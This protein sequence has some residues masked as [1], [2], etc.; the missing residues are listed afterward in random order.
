M[1]VSCLFF[2]PEALS[3]HSVSLWI[4]YSD[5]PDFENYLG[6][7]YP[8]EPEIKDTKE[9]IPSASYLDLLPSTVRDGKLHTSIYDKREDFNFQITNFSFLSSHIPSSPVNGVFISHLIRYARACSSYECF[10]PRAT[11]LCSKLL[12][13]KYLV[14]YLISS[15]RKSYGRY[16]D[17]IQ[18]FEVSLSRIFNDILTL[19]QFQ[20]LTNRSDFPTISWRWYRALSPPNYEW[21]SW[22]MCSGCGM[23]A[24][25][26]Y[27]SGHLVPSPFL[28]LAYAPIL[29]R[30]VFRNLPCLFTTIH[31]EYPS[32]LSWVFIAK[33]NSE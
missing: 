32:V 23:P 8:A 22:S 17:L 20:W 33:K 25:N 6:Q 11:R 15:F 12:K 30:P 26:A 14:E 2:K 19:D 21:S 1:H 7:V 5:N 18:Q 10:I 24:G 27:S 3:K 9:S 4:G 13:E 16:W 28:R 29:L 31:L